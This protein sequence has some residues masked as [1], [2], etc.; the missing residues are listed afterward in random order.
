MLGK[1]GSRAAL[2]AVLVLGCA[3]A[4][5]AADVTLDLKSFKFLVEEDAKSLFG[6]NEDEGKLF[7]YTGGKAEAV[8]K[9]PSDGE[10]EIVL[11]ASGDKAEDVRAKFKV[12][13]DG[14]AVGAETTLSA[15]EPKEY[16]FSVKL[17]AGDMKLSVEF[18]NDAYKENEFDRNF[19][20]HAATIKGK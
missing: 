8:A 19:Y 4:A 7:F 3:G 2:A 14:E 17:K 11:K 18:T 6:Y 10:Y 5:L 20:L 12:A 9:I 15:D 1:R 16:K 13:V